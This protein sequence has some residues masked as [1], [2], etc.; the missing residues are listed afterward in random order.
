MRCY[1]KNFGQ[2]K[3]AVCEELLPNGALL[4]ATEPVQDD[5]PPTLWARLGALIAKSGEL[6][7]AQ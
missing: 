7:E 4:T 6:V 3:L 5:P 2:Q 1:I